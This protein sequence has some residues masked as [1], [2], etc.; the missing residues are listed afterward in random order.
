MTSMR[1]DPTKKRPVALRRRGKGQDARRDPYR[2]PA[3]THSDKR[4]RQKQKRQ[5][6]QAETESLAGTESPASRSDLGTSIP[7]IGRLSL[8]GI[9]APTAPLGVQDAYCSGDP[10]TDERAKSTER[11]SPEGY[12]EVNGHQEWPDRF[13]YCGELFT[14][15]DVDASGD[16]AGYLTERTGDIINEISWNDLYPDSSPRET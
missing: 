8:S 3:S 13:E 2:N 11:K 14:L 15:H 12:H 6:Q 4:N 7:D 1:A 9:D 5:D 10:T 16:F